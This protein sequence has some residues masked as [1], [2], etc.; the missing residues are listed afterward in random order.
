MGH[1]RGV[2]FGVGR[3][4]SHPVS[5]ICSCGRLLVSCLMFEP[6]QHVQV[7]VLCRNRRLEMS[8]SSLEWWRCPGGQEERRFQPHGFLRSGV[9]DLQGD[10]QR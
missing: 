10:D 1:G 5:E 9:G 2:G 4:G 6:G 7:C 8:L 3:C